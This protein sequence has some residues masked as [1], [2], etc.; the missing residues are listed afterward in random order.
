MPRLRQVPLAE[1]HPNAQKYYQALFSGRDPAVA[2]GTETGTPGDWWT[3]LAL[4]P[5]VFDHA[6]AHLAMYGMFAAESASQL[7]PRARELALTRVGYTVGSQFVYSQHCKASVLVGIEDEK[8]QAVPHWNA[9]DIW[10]PL[11]RAILAYAD[12]VVYD[13]GRVPDGVFAALKALMSDGDIMELTY[14]ISGYIMHATF[15]KAL[16]LEYDNVPERIVEV[17]VPGGADFRTW[18]AK[19][20]VDRKLASAK[21]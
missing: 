4:R 21:K 10:S 11:E 8:I 17:P 15:T 12:A 13:F 3:T 6:V 14:H 1:A 19:H 18:A 20:G 9:L 7:D 5:Y 2:P 16:R